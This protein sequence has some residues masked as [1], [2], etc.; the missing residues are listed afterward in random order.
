MKYKVQRSIFDMF[1]CTVHHSTWITSRPVSPQQHLGGC[2]VLSAEDVWCSIEVHWLQ[3]NT[4]ALSLECSDY[5]LLFSLNL[6]KN[7]FEASYVDQ[8]IAAAGAW[9]SILGFHPL[10]SPAYPSRFMIVLNTSPIELL[11]KRSQPHTPWGSKWVLLLSWKW[12]QVIAV[13]Q[14]KQKL[15]K[16]PHG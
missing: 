1:W 10:I 12:K 7:D 6:S 8:Q 4:W 9:N 15:K 13:K 2:F 14:E 11:E 5:F 3:E 16:L